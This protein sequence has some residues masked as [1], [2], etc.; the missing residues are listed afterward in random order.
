M[1]FLPGRCRPLL[2]AALS[3]TLAG[4]TLGP[5]YQRPSPPPAPAA[6]KELPPPNPPNGTWKQAQPSDATLKGKWWEIYNDSRLNDLE[7]KVAVSNQTLKAA[8]EQYLQAREQVRVARSSYYPTL[9]AGPSISRQRT[10]DNSPSATKGLTYNTFA[11]T[12]QVLW[13]PDL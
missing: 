8:V 4:C 9:S 5:N 12:G 1:R 3:L 10:T 13:E 7:E 2:A 6:Y 11:L